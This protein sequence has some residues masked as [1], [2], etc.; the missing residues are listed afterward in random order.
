MAGAGQ[1]FYM[2]I[3]WPVGHVT[4]ALTRDVDEAPPQKPTP[5]PELDLKGHLTSMCASARSFLLALAAIYLV[6]PDGSYPAFGRAATLEWS[7]MWPII[8]RDLLA[9]WIICGCWDYFLYFGF[10]FPWLKQKMAKY[11]MNPKYPSNSQIIHD[12]TVTTIASLTGAGVEI[13]CCHF[14]CTGMFPK[15]NPILSSNPIWNLMWAVTITHWR[16]PHFWLIHRSMHP[17]KINGIPDVGKFL[18]RYV[19]SLHHKSYNPTAF[20]GTNMHPVES[21]LYYS[22]CLIF[23]PFGCHPAVVLGCIFDCA[24]GAW[25]G[26]DG[27]QYPGSGDYFHLLHHANFDCNYGAM[28]VPIDKWLGTYIGDKNDLKKVWGTKPAGA[29]ANETSVHASKKE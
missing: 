2:P 27:F 15:F 19:H 28:H 21:T 1:P 13:M 29:D 10:G 14:W 16:V 18:Y 8:L 6:Y 17:W 24:V 12:A 5:T 26:H 11:K 20:S 3:T 23:V 4:S 9:T 7:W 22:A 25:L